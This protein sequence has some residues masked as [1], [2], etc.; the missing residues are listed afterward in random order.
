MPSLDAAQHPRL[1]VSAP[2]RAHVPYQALAHRPKYFGNGFIESRRLRQYLGDGVLRHEALLGP[3]ALGDVLDRAEHAAGP[4]RLVPH[5]IALTVD[6]THLA[7]GP[8]HSVLHVVA[9]ATTQRLRHGLDHDLPIFRVD[10]F[11]IPAR[12]MARSWGS[13][14][15]MR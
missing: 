9:R 13:S 15:K 5:H 10:Q 8:D 6:E 1:V 11:R 7:V 14:P 2:Q 4:A 3:L 12:F